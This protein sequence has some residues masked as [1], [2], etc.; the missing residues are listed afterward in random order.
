MAAACSRLPL[1][2]TATNCSK[3]A[4]S[5]LQQ[6]DDAINLLQTQNAE[7]FS[8]DQVLSR[9]RY[10]VGLI[11]NLAAKGYCANF[12]GEELA[13][14]NTGGYSDQY[15]VITSAMTVRRGANSYRA[16]CY[17]AALPTPPPALAPT[18]GCSLPPSKDVACGREETQ[19]LPQVEAALAQ[20]IKEH[21]EYFNLN[22]MQK[23]TDW[24]RVVNEDAYF[25][26]VV[27]AVGKNGICARFDGEELAVKRDN[28]GSEQFDIHTSLGYIR[29]GEGSYRASC[30]PAAF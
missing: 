2:P 29:R 17:P 26:A 14:T 20:V 18:A 19:F 22:D 16:T 15:H 25:N 7:I 6:V 1:A 10:L 13:V 24:V 9:G 27:A 12:D 28:K 11:E 8:G 23:G 3:E 5:Y 4:P 30:Y 21:P